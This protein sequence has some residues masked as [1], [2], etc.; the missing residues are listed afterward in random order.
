[1]KS[2]HVNRLLLTLCFLSLL[3]LPLAAAPAKKPVAKLPD[4]EFSF[5]GQTLRAASIKPVKLKSVYQND[6]S[7]AWRE[8]QKRDVAPVLSSLQTLTEQMGLNDWFV[9]RLVRG[10]PMGC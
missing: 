4:L 2:I 7:T 3:A 9:F 8:Y 1:M 5:Y 6:V 10:M